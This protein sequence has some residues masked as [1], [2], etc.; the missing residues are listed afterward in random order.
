MLKNYFKIAWRNLLKNKASSVINVVGLS[1]GISACLVIYLIT[2]FELSYE[3]FH[4]GK[5]RIYRAVTD[6]DNNEGGLFHR[7]VISYSSA[8][9]IRNQFTGVD[10][11]A[12]FFSYYFKVTVPVKNENSKLFDV[13]DASKDPSDMIITE[14]QFFDIFKYDWLAGNAATALNEPFKVVLTES[15]ARVYFGSLRP[16]EIMGKEVI[17]NDSL[18]LTVS[19]IVKDLGKNTNI[20]F[21]D[22]ISFST[23][24]ASFLNNSPGFQDV[25]DPGKW[26]HTDFGQVYIKLSKGTT[27]AEFEAQTPSLIK[28][29]KGVMGASTGFKLRIGLQPI[30]DIHFNA[31]YSQD[32]YSRQVS[33]PTLYGLMGIAAF[34]LIIASI[35]FVNLSTAQSIRRAKEIGIRKVLGSGRI[36]IGLQFLGEAFLLV[37]FAV[38]LSVI[39][40]NPALGAFR[41]FIPDGVTFNLLSPSVI[42][43]LLL[44][45]IVTVLLAGFYPAKVLSSYLPALSLKGTGA[46]LLNEKGYLRKTLIVFQFTVSLLFIIGTI[47]IGQQVHFML[48]KS[49]GFNK[50]AII[51]IN[52]SDNYSRDKKY[53]FA[54]SLKEIPGIE[55]VSVSQEPPET[56]GTRGGLLVCK[57]MGTQIQQAVARAGD[58]NY[59][60]LYG[61]KI[62]AGRNF[63]VPQGKDSLTE[64]LINETCA[65]QLGFKRP[66]DAIGHTVQTGYFRQSQFHAINT[67]SVAGIVADFNA[68][69]LNS[70]MSPVSIL[71][72]KDLYYGTV[73]VKLA[74]YGKQITDFNAAIGGIEKK[75]KEVYPNEKLT[76]S[77]YDKTIA[78]FY[79]EQQK[80]SQIMN[81]AMLVAILLSCMGLFGLAAFTAEQRTKEIGIRKVLGASVADITSMLSKEFIKLVLVAIVIASPIAWYFMHNWLQGF[82]YRIE[83]SWWVFIMSG[84]GAVLITLLTISFRAIKAAIANPVKSLRTE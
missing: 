43:F 77:F 20:I 1:V 10:K 37:C 69:P 78:S 23:I 56:N 83:I 2:S 80:A 22:F 71:A 32:F 24:N 84:I 19:G 62:V 4:P 45:T 70:S 64:F 72:S 73:N 63:R 66:A 55:K 76:Y 18:R 16:D 3:N 21:N 33:L 58:E 29:L 31:D 6:M 39:I 59:I 48:N 61:L 26:R 51:T 9:F 67:G 82:A 17:Y 60:P 52:T 65:K 53:V 75:W 12:D 28:K 42:V 14:P 5:E 30:S 35:N 8:F 40:I 25:A 74:T 44:I 81:A 11:V 57:D 46:Q 49:L 68:Q 15:K 7:P 13:P 41:S 36:S 50:D 79:D 27:P 38:I 54:E 47:I 34:I